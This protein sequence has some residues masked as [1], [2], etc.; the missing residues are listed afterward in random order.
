M[1]KRILLAGVMTLVSSAAFGQTPSGPG[2]GAPVTEPGHELN[3]SLQHY[4]YTEPGDLNISIHGPKVGAEYT[5]TFASN[6]PQHWFAQ[7][8]LRATGG[9]AAYDGWCQP[10]QITPSST[11]PNGYRLT[12]GSASP[13]SETGDADWYAEGRVLAGKD[14]VGQTWGVSP[15]AG[16]G[17]RYLSN[18]TTGNPGFRTDNYFYVPLGLT[19][20]AKTSSDR[21]LG[22]T[23]EYDHLIRGWQHTHDSKLGG[24]VVPATATAP[25]F[26]LANFTD[27]AFDQRSGACTDSPGTCSAGFALRAS[28][29]YQM[30]RRWSIEPYYMRWRVSSSPVSSGSVDFTVNSVTVRQQLHA[31]EPLNMTNELGVK[32]GVRFGRR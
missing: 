23:L 31:F 17:L 26:T 27:F 11:S 5:G 9:R 8:N 4:D 28:A 14:F 7:V 13:C 15:F 30:T 32:I 3:V 22:L 2:A 20:R 16:V 10:W 18:G 21:V 6:S 29:S 19:V 24:G 12:L 25:S 1:T